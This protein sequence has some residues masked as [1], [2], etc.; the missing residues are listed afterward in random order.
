MTIPEYN[1]TGTSSNAQWDDY[2]PEHGAP[3]VYWDDYI[4]EQG[5]S[6]SQW[7]NYMPQQS[8]SQWDDEYVPEQYYQYNKANSDEAA[9]SQGN[10]SDPYTNNVKW[11][12]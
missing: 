3:N 4:P 2:I 5:A 7:D 6:D 1:D 11:E 12:E 10:K 8:N 9:N